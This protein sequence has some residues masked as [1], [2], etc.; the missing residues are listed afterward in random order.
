MKRYE[1]ITFIEK[2][3]NSPQSIILE[4]TKETDVFL[5]GIEIDREGDEI[6]RGKVDV[7][8]HLISKDMIAKRVELV[9]NNTFGMLERKK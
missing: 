3:K 1:R 2:P 5:C 4:I 8:R 6:R 7:T 9:M